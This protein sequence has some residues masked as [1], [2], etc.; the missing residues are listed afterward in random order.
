MAAHLSAKKAETIHV[1]KNRTTKQIHFTLSKDIS[2]VGK[3]TD[4]T[5]APIENVCVIITEQCD[6]GWAGEAISDAQ[7]E[8]VISGISEGVY[9]AH[10]EASCYHDQAYEDQWWHSENLV[11]ECEFAE[12]VEVVKTNMKVPIN[13]ELSE[14]PDQ[15]FESLTHPKLINGRYE[16]KIDGGK[17]EINI[18][19]NIIDIVVES[20]SLEN[21]LKIISKYTGIKV[22][23]FGTLQ[24]K[25]YFEKK[26]SK[27]DDILLDLI[28][29]RAG[30][31]F[32]YSPDRLLTT[33]IFSKDGELKSKAFSP[34]PGPISSQ[35]KDMGVMEADEIETIL[36]SKGQIEQKLEALSRLIGYFSSENA[37]R[38]L[39]ISL[40][41]NDDE[42]R[43][44]A[45][46]VM[47]DLK[48]NH[49]AVD[50]LSQ[51][52]NR[53]T[54]PAVRALAAESLGQIGDKSAIRPLMEA[55]NDKDAGVRDIARRAIQEIQG[56]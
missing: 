14:K 51:S 27:L 5:G 45:I 25:I 1:Q 22:L 15:V 49:L 11:S 10:T 50:D 34:N 23:L 24:E 29:G 16:E 43:M 17:V 9:Y 44:M 37:L 3:I 30:H 8:F 33:Y 36:Y 46:S 18:L 39:K 31:I 52:L 2:F 19:D 21:V 42:V 6:N 56:R 40:N 13:F 7:G 38:L 54:S 4:N 47:N 55:L 48:D 53:D 28:N 12:P 35:Q 26:Q 41:D 32:I 20:V